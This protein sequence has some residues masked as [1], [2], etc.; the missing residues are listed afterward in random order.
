MREVALRKGWV[1]V[2]RDPI[3]VTASVPH[4]FCGE[5]PQWVGPAAIVL[6]IPCFLFHLQRAHV[7]ISGVSRSLKWFLETLYTP[8][9]LY[10]KNVCVH[11]YVCVY[12]SI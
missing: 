11:V 10:D 3:T 1:P 8:L 4:L 2:T 6:L 9:K 5:N 12:I 7:L